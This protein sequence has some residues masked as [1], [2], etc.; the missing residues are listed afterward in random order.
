MKK[1][2]ALV[3][4]VIL[5][6]VGVGLSACTAT[7]QTGSQTTSTNIPSLSMDT[8]WHNADRY[9]DQVVRVTGILYTIDSAG[10]NE[11]I[12]QLYGPKAINGINELSCTI[13]C[14]SAALS[15]LCVDE[16]ITIQGTVVSHHIYPV[17]QNCTI[18]KAGN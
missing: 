10:G 7:T 3:I 8:V 11:Y 14:D 17:I 4:A 5:I 9:N 18:I 6:A 12:L 15:S 16:S 2:L 13:F 1:Y